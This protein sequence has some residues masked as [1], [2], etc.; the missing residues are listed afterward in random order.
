MAASP[1]SGPEL[2]AAIDRLY[3]L[4]VAEFTEA[5]NALAAA[6]R[7]AGDEAGAALVKALAKPTLVAWVVNLLYFKHRELFDGLASAMTELAAAQREAR[8][9]EGGPE[10]REAARRKSEA[11]QKLVRVAERRLLDGGG[12]A[13]PPVLQRVGGTLEVLATPRPEGAASPRPG[14]LVT[15]LRPAGFDV[16]LGLGALDLPPMTPLAASEPAGPAADAAA[17]PVS[18][19][20]PDAARRSRLAIQQAEL[21]LAGRRRETEAALRALAEA[22]ARTAAARADVAQLEARLAQTRARAEERAVAESDARRA[23]EA[24]RDDLAAAEAALEAQKQGA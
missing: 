3:Q 2:E 10:L 16:A 7:A 18:G 4:P 5:R 9:G 24:A 12:Q 13:P 20:E 11:L 1:G 19:A 17:P 14:R 22:E 23:L 15:E 8:S 21:E 6:R